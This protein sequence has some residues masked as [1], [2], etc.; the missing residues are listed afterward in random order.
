M[1]RKIK[2]LI[3]IFCEGESEIEY[4]KCLKEQFSDVAVIKKPV[5]SGF[6][7][8]LIMNK[9]EAGI[10]IIK[11]FVLCVNCENVPTFAYDC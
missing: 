6:S 9:P 2:P 5:K 4:G 10:R 3:Y 1:E 8:M 11:L 7:L